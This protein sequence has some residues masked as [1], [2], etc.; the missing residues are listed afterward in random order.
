MATRKTTT[1]KKAVKKGKTKSTK[2]PQVTGTTQELGPRRG[3]TL[4]ATRVASQT[5]LPEDFH[6]LYD[7]GFRAARGI[8]PAVA[9]QPRSAGHTRLA[10]DVPDLEVDYDQATQL[11]NRIVSRHP[12]ARLSTRAV[13]SPEQAV[14]D[15]IRSRADL[16][17]LSPD[18]AKTVEVVSTSKTGLPTVNLIQRVEGKE[19]FNSDVTAS[20]G[21]NNE[22]V[23]VAGQFF[24]G[25]AATASRTRAKAAAITSAQEAIAKAATDLTS[26]QYKASD[27]SKVKAPKDSGPYRFYEFKPKGGDTRPHFQRPVRLKDVMFPLGENQF[28]PGYYMELW[29]KGFP[30]FSYVMDA[31]DTPDVLYRKNLTHAVAFKYRVHNTGNGMFQ[32]EDGP[33]PGTPHP[34]GFPNGFQAPTVPQK[35]ISLE[36]LLPG[37]PW[38]PPGATT[39]KGNNCF[40]YADLKPPDGFNSG[41]VVGKITSTRTFDHVYDHSNAASVAKN[42][43]A[44]IVGMFF[45]VNWL[46]D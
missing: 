14:T 31:I 34:T 28:V 7:R 10:A 11:P 2:A 23:S 32:P 13:A 38:L 3:A 12:S 44:S 46:Q 41:D 22:V 15:F 5:V 35:L 33:A 17:H 30:T 1:R 25:A 16:W 19:V 4:Q 26:I 37:K 40:A 6:A 20:V 39:T 24:P 27:F 36:S 42:L 9:P 18:D 43:Q 29:I 21:P 8:T 45:H